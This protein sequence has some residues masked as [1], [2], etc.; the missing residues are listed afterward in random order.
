MSLVKVNKEQSEK[1]GRIV[2]QLSFKTSFLQRDFIQLQVRKEIKA[3][4]YF[5]AV[6][7]CH[8]TYHLANKKLNLFGWD[9]L[10]YGFMVIATQKPELLDARYLVNL[11]PTDLIPL[12]QPFFAEDHQKEK[13]TLDSLEERAEIWLDMAHFLVAGNINFQDFIQLS[14]KK[15]SY[16]Y[17]NLPKTLAYSDPLQKK[18]SFLLKL[19]EDSSLLKTEDAVNLIPIMDYHMQRVLL[20]TGCVEILDQDLQQKLQNRIAIESDIEIREA[21]I[22]SMKLIAQTDGLSI[23]K[24]NDVFYTMG[25][26]CCN[27]NMLCETHTCEKSPCTLTLAVELKSHDN[28]IF[29]D[30]CLG[31]TKE[32]YRKYWQPQVNTHFY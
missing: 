31:A 20:R 5:Y 32:E 13:C 8:Q 19:L 30:I 24:M 9:F 12:I 16:F 17:E 22:E 26:S 11:S 25:R 27:D 6:G 4:M 3:A 29:Q 23:L 15:A 7:I 18:T 28:C 1:L 14:N 2:G 21:C 10:E